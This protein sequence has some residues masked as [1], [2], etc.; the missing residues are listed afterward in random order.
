MTAG[1]SAADLALFEDGLR[2]AFG[3]GAS[4]SR[5]GDENR[6]PMTFVLERVAARLDRPHVLYWVEDCAPDLFSLRSDAG[7]AAVFNR[8][9]LEL[10]AQLLNL[11]TFPGDGELICELSE[12]LFL[13]IIGECALRHGDADLAVLCYVKGRLDERVVIP[14]ARNVLELELSPINERY[15]FLWFFGLVHEFG[16]EH[17]AQASRRAWM[18]EWLPDHAVHAELRE[19]LDGENLPAEL[20]PRAEEVLAGSPLFSPAGLREESAADLFACE[21]LL[22]S[23]LDIFGELSLGPVDPVG[24]AVEHIIFMN[25][26]MFIERCRII[27]EMASPRAAADKTPIIKLALH[28]VAITFRARLAQ[29]YLQQALVQAQGLSPEKLERA[30]EEAQSGFAARRDMI[31]KG[32]RNALRYAL[33]AKRQ[34]EDHPLLDRFREGIRSPLATATAQETRAF[35]E[36]ARAM[37]VEGGLLAVLEGILDRPDQPFSLPIDSASRFVVA[38]VT[39]PDGFSAPFPISTEAGPVVTAFLPGNPLFASLCEA[40]GESL[41]PGF[42]LKRT[43]FVVPRPEALGEVMFQ[44]VSGVPGFGLICEGQPGFEAFLAEHVLPAGD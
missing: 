35:C 42:E 13:R 44:H 19:G 25:I 28:H 21:V 43:V 14:D 7:V 9:H 6:T 26:L 2:E 17:A 34:V 15:M 31:Q 11:F 8:R 18:A 22:Q 30:I 4:I 37:G 40:F 12:R 36:T 24:F 29:W 32:Y 39:G 1:F 16:H 5:Y 23:T 3:K 10:S 38:W 41:R 33:G 20:R 27:A